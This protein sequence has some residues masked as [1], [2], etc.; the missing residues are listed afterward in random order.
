[1]TTATVATQLTVPRPP[2]LALP[3]ELEGTRMAHFRPAVER[4]ASIK[5]AIVRWLDA[6]L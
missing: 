6:E 3:R 2:P 1:V 5:E 4:P